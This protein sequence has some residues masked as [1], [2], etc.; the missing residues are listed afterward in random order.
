[1]TEF[2][3][4]DVGEET[5]HA[6]SVLR[7]DEGA[8]V[9]G[10][11]L[12]RTCQIGAQEACRLTCQLAEKPMTDEVATAVAAKHCP[13]A[14]LKEALDALH[15]PVEQVLMVGAIADKVG[16]A[17]ELG[18]YDVKRAPGGWQEL[19][20]YDAFFTRTG[21]LAGIGT[22]MA[23]CAAINFEFTAEDG[24]TV[25]G[26][27]HGTRK[28]LYGSGNFAYETPD[29][30]KVSYTEY[31]IDRAIRHYG[32]DPATIKVNLASGIQGK[33][34]KWSF[35][36]YE[37]IAHYFPGW[38]E[39]GFLVNGTN[40]DWKLGDPV[41]AG[42]IWHADERG[43]VI[44]DLEVAAES[45]GIPPTNIDRSSMLDAYE[46]RANHSSHSANAQAGLIDTAD[47]YLVYRRP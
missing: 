32:A 4:S 40:P 35:S 13:D 29:G 44:R 27:E 11:I 21:E 41:V 26:F 36:D 28:N 31:V 38:Y 42:D 33:N 43:M 8:M 10:N 6:I 23:D 19:S 47:L 18:N 39:D 17:D 34:Y 5:A 1:M 45:L 2:V 12:R 25:F 20:G 37:K 14:N 7:D 30:R 24:S 3:H 16:F 15:V 22:R 46:N 9:T